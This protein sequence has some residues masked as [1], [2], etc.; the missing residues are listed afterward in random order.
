MTIL[1]RLRCLARGAGHA[2]AFITWIARRDFEGQ[3]WREIH[4]AGVRRQIKDARAGHNRFQKLLE[5][6]ERMLDA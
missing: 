1:F 6:A 4:W 5:A 3:L 2:L